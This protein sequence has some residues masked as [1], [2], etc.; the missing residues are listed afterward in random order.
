MTSEPIRLRPVPSAPSFRA[1]ARRGLVLV[2]LLAAV[3]AAAL[4]ASAA[5]ERLEKGSLE[6]K[7][8]RIRFG[9]APGEASPAE[10]R[11]HGTVEDRWGRRY[12][13]YIAWDRDATLAAF[14]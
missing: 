6:L 4:P 5:L 12:T 2:L 8:D 13:G 11:L 3:L 14:E 10:G 1:A 9:S 7:L